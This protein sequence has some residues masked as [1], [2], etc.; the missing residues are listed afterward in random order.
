MTDVI[1][2][3]S[4][5]YVHSQCGQETEVGGQAFE[6]VSN[7]MSSMEQTQCSNCG[8]MYPIS[9]FSWA[10]TGETIS[11]YYA[12]HTTNASNRQRF[13]CSKRFMVVVIGIAAIV[14]ASAFYALVANDN[15][16]TRLICVA[17]GLMVGAMI[18]MAV[19]LTG[20]ANPIKRKVCGVPD[21]RALR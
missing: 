9:E 18:G 6:V 2:P 19:F 14:T 11:A 10:D 4:R 20:F 12:R 7:P 1:I 13:L 5:T 8:S 16:L 3:E 17:G 21:T 15:L